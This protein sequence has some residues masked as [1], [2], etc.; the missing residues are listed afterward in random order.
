M[1]A[2]DGLDGGVARGI[3]VSEFDDVVGQ[4]PLPVLKTRKPGS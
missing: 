2:G 3:E 1:Q 4:G